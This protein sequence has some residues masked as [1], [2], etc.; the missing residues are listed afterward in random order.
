MIWYNGKYT[1]QWWWWWWWWCLFVRPSARLSRVSVSWGEDSLTVRPQGALYNKDMTTT[2]MRI[3]VTF[4]KMKECT[5]TFF[6]KS[7]WIN[8]A[9]APQSD[10]NAAKVTFVLSQRKTTSSHFGTKCFYF[11][12]LGQNFEDKCYD[13]NSVIRKEGWW[14][15][16]KSSQV[17]QKFLK[18]EQKKRKR[19]RG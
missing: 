1:C 11:P 7:L 10:A 2:V 6:Q 5:F 19:E 17:W 18:A 13:N 15:S 14:N 9:T 3:L 8:L 4:P 16:C 12:F